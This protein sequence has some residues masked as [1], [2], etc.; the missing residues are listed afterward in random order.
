MESDKE[1][2]EMMATVPC[3]LWNLE[4]SRRM[5]ALALRGAETRIEGYAARLHS[6]RIPVETVSPTEVAAMINYLSIFAGVTVRSR[7]TSDE[8]IKYLF[9]RYHGIG[10]SI[11][12]VIVTA[13]GNPDEGVT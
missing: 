1:F 11:V 10:V 12:P 5:R 3:R 4:D 2:V 9:D 7:S 8:E 13:L 6:G